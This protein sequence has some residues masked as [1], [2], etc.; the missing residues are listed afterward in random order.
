M[1]PLRVKPLLF[2][3]VTFALAA[4]GVVDE[5]SATAARKR[6]CAKLHLSY[7]LRTVEP[8]QVFDY[9]EAIVNCSNSPR[10]IRVRISAFGP[11]QFAHP[12]SA[13]YRLAGGL[14][15]QSDA[16]ILAPPC[17][18]HYRIV[19]KAIIRGSVVARAHASFTV[20]PH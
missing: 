11:C 7:S 4:G 16:L 18:G 9:S 14:G 10:T 8:G 1:S 17:P 12:S 19:G 6:P 15:V 3:L 20:L 13:K 2:G 5:R